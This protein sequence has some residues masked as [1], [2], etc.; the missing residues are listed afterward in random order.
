MKQHRRASRLGV[1]G[2][3]R[4]EQ[5]EMLAVGSLERGRGLGS[6]QI[7]QPLESPDLM[8][9]LAE[10]EIARMIGNRQVEGEIES[11]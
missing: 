2:A 1:S 6:G 9:R 8:K 7:R 10:S 5:G 4:R 11:L 3:K